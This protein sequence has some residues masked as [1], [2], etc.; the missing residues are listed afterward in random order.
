MRKIVQ[1][2]GATATGGYGDLEERCFALCNDGTVWSSWCDW[3]GGDKC[4]KWE[5]LPD[6]PQEVTDEH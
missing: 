3:H 5:R 2:A 6:I 1:I 4:I